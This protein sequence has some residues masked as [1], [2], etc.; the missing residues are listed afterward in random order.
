MF[1]PAGGYIIL[2]DKDFLEVF[3]ENLVNN[4]VDCWHFYRLRVP[5]QVFLNFY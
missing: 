4:F 1:V 2:E 5:L 3:L